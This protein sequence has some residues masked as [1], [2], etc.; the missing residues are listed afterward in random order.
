MLL[1]IPGPV[2][3][4]PE[5]RAAMAQ[6]LAPWDTD[7]R[8]IYARV[9]SR[10]LAIGH[11]TPETHVA[12][13]LQGCGHFATEAALR[14]FVPA[15][16]RI[17][18]PMTGHY[19]DRMADLAT[20]AGRVPVPLAV[21]QTEPVDPALVAEAL[22]ADR[23]ISH[24][25]LIYSETSSGV[26]HDPAAVGAAV[27]GAGRRLLLDSVSAFGALPLDVSAQP[28]L[29]AAWFTTNKCLEG[30]PGMSYTL[31]RADRLAAVPAGQAGS[32][33][34]DLADIFEHGKR[35]GQGTARFTPAIQVVA[36]FDTALD[37]YD[38]EGGQPARLARYRENADTLHRGMHGI[39]LLPTLAIEAQGPIVLNVD[40]P[41]DP[42]WSLQ[43]FVDGL[44]ARNYL[45][46]N[47]YNT[48]HPSFRVGCI[49]A[50][51]PK[52]MRGFVAAADVV[53]SAMGVRNRESSRRAA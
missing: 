37:F 8:P 49:G 40:A 23:S 2:T 29:D 51:T 21:V 11:G 39:G 52:D 53:L 18:I 24:V 43:G 50:I 31:A 33:A 22:E 15:G 47:F 38:A 7:V 16:G 1:M 26:I 14:T 13:P 41:D 4:R 27:R 6:D 35:A 36:S 44:K 25:G 42:A 46:S 9:R 17:L 30:L 3:T 32:W 20:E 48:Q 28:E 10:V 12:L 34:F 45:I 5:V 19:A